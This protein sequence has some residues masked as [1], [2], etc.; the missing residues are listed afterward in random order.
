MRVNFVES[1]V[2]LVDRDNILRDLID[3]VVWAKRNVI[4]YLSNSSVEPHI[5]PISLFY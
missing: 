1:H 3:M 2:R 4:F 5:D